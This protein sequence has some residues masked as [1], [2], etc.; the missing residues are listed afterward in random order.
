MASMSGDPLVGNTYQ[1]SDAD[2]DKL[3]GIP[4]SWIQVP[5][6]IFVIG[7][8]RSGA[9]LLA[10]ALGQHSDIVMV[11][12]AAW[13][14]RFALGLQ[15][16]VDEDKDLGELSQLAAIGVDQVRFFAEFG[17]GINSLMLGGSRGAGQEDPSAPIPAGERSW[18]DFGKAPDRQLAV[19]HAYAPTRWVDSCYTHC[20]I[21][22]T[23]RRLFPEA[24]FIHTVRD[25]HDTVAALTDPTNSVA[26]KSRHVGF[27]EQDAWEHWLESVTACVAAERALGPDAVLR[28]RWDELV[29]D[30]QGAIQRSLR[31]LREPFEPACLRP[32]TPAPKLATT[33]RDVIPE[34]VPEELRVQA[35]AL[36]YALLAD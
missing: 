28:L 30:P 29:T 20:F 4:D 14:E 17:K 19:G 1:L 12:D 8:R 35:E 18:R 2:G 36:S 7:A 24:Q 16:T 6:P 11:P 23:L 21:V 22:P 32:L 34:G 10:A 27:S 9:S 26:Y 3:R 5:R 25:V 33:D 15:A 13:L 31:F